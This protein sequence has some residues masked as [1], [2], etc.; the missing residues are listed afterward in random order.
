[1]LILNS[2]V[3]TQPLLLGQK[4]QKFSMRKIQKTMKTKTEDEEEK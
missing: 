2:S 3:D 4:K 1:M